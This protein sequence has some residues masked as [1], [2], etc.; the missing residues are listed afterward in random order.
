MPFSDNIIFFDTE[1]STLDPR[2][3]EILSIGMVKM[4]GEEL[5]LEIDHTSEVSE[6]VKENVLPLLSGEKVG[7]EEAEQKIFEF[8]G[9]TH[10]F[11]MSYVI[12]FDAPFLYK[13]LGVNENKGN[14]ELPFHWIILD[15]ASILFAA[16]ENPT[17]FVENEKMKLL[18]K[19][20]IASP[21][22]REH[23]ALDDAKLLR[24]VYLKFVEQRKI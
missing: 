15:F 18:Q 12:A 3:G 2:T 20:D 21:S 19:L 1:F 22:Y 5:Y 11:L 13:L 8:V 6:W 24:E 16:G 14:R 17:A 23:H 7:P 4:T 9:D 10:S